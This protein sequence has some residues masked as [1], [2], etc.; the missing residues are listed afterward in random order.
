MVSEIFEFLGS[1]VSRLKRVRYGPVI[2]PSWLKTGQYTEL[3]VT[4]VS[5]LY[6]LVGLS[7]AD[8]NK[9][10]KKSRKSKY[11]AIKS[12]LIDYPNPV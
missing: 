3:N 5:K 1:P 10:I 8:K 4:D 7:G 9:T 6:R 12:C 11:Q 2:T